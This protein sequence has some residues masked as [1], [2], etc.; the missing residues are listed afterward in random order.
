MT[1]QMANISS[2]TSKNSYA[3][4]LALRIPPFNWRA[5]AHRS[6]KSL[7][8]RT[9]RLPPNISLS[10]FGR[11][12]TMRR[13]FLLQR[14]DEG[15]W[16]GFPGEPA[17]CMPL[18]CRAA[19]TTQDPS[20]LPSFLWMPFLSASTQGVG[21]IAQAKPRSLV[22]GLLGGRADEVTEWRM[23]RDADIILEILEMLR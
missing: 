9:L 18:V 2:E 13:S 5:T 4:N 23:R 6:F 10:I 12:K 21:L 11:M 8:G 17:R 20:T 14:N 3:G 7:A 16:S 22:T 1:S 19:E 15:K